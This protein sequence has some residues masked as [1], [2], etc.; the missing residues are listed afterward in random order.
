[1][2]PSEHEAG[3]IGNRGS[4]V[5]ALSLTGIVAAL[6]F[7]QFVSH[8]HPEIYWL[9][10]FHRTLPTPAATAV[11]VAF[12]GYLFWLAI[13]FYR[14]AK[15]RERVLVAGL[16]LPIFLGPIRSVV[17]MSAAAAITYAR[18]FCTLIALLAAVDIFLKVFTSNDSK[19]QN[20]AAS[21]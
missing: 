5:V 11:E 20:Q 1:M 18:A 12:Y 9:L 8:P 3:L 2:E 19:A 4:A 10:D 17:S 16:F 14:A 15:G 6:S 21:K 13:V 7:R